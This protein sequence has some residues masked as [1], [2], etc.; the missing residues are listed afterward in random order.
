MA[1]HSG[2]QRVALI[3]TGGIA[4][5]F[6]DALKEI[7][8]VALVA[9]CARTPGKATTFL[10]GVSDDAG[11]PA[12]GYTDAEEM[13]RTE[14]P[15]FVIDCS[16]S[17]VHAVHIKLCAAVGVDL[18]TE[19]PIVMNG[20]QLHEAV[21]VVAAAGILVGGIFQHRFLRCYQ[22]LH[23]AISAGRF[24]QLSAINIAVPWYR[25]ASYYQAG[26]WRGKPE[27]DGGAVMNQGVH[28]V[29]LALWLAS[30]AMRLP[31]GQN[32][33]EMLSAFSTNVAHKDVISVED[34]AT[35]SV[36]FRN[37]AL[38]S[39]YFTT[40]ANGAQE[41]AKSLS[42]FGSEGSVV[43]A[44]NAVS[45]WDFVNELPTD[46]EIR[47]E[48]GVSSGGNA[49]KNPLAISHGPHRAN[50]EAFMTWRDEG[51]EFDLDLV[52]AGLAPVTV[53]SIY[54]SAGSEG[55]VLAPP[56]LGHLVSRLA[57]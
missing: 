16:P 31:H 5:K 56:N 53:A 27:S 24:G 11:Q 18:L 51:G 33:V 4:G 10:N 2:C 32:P 26:E 37:G 39:W 46:A 17:G 14:H 6:R 9:G 41:G 55:T 38:G 29:D 1:V 28:E 43:I 40:A 7:P 50:I 19:K 57:G 23:A 35:V 25:G 12:R 52:G 3:G 21:E 30:A 44:G 13:L 48:L 36:R 20:E 15:D 42:V 22:E 47:A 54:K 45:R 34:T 49:S 8:S